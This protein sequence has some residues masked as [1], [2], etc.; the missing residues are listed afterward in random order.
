MLRVGMV[1]VV[2]ALLCSTSAHA[3]SAGWTISEASGRVVIRDSAGDHP[4]A[5]GAAIPSGA[6]VMTGP[7]GRAIL[8]RGQDFVTL[9]ANA[10]MRLPVAAQSGG[11]FQMIQEWGNALFRIEHRKD[12]R[13]AVQ[14]PYLAAVVKGTTF[15][16]TVT[17]EGSSVQVIEGAVEA[18]TADGGAHELIRPGAVASVMASDRFRLTVQGQNAHSVD[19]PARGR[20]GATAPA[21]PTPNGA[22]SGGDHNDGGAVDASGGSG[23]H[24]AGYDDIAWADVA[25][26]VVAAPIEAKPADLGKITDGLVSGKSNG[27]AVAS[28]V[29][30]ARAETSGSGNG[31]LGGV[32]TGN[33]KGS[34]AGTSGNS[35]GSSSGNGSGSG[36]GASDN[37]SGNG[38]GN[39]GNGNGNGGGSD[40]GNGSG[41]GNGNSGNGNGNGGGDGNNPG[42]GNTNPGNGNGNGNGGGGKPKG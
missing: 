8:V 33:G 20:G 14:A 6:T 24:A 7:N 41:N 11:L 26:S 29:A 22:S 18:A 30:I 40:N 32:S 21:A 31:N 25:N 27:T 9:S 28:A 39:S 19:S 38:N 42:N 12:P 37:G 16:V 13:F 36:S 4:G 2:A 5:R 10:R 15:S 34:S 35:G 17:R 23:S 3:Q 1:A